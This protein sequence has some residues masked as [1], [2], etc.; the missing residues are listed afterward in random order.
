MRILARCYGES[1]ERISTIADVALDAMEHDAH[2]AVLDN[3]GR[4]SKGDVGAF[5]KALDDFGLMEL[6]ALAAQVARRLTFLDHLDE[7][8]ANPATLEKQIHVA[9]ESNLWVLGRNYDSM[10]SNKTLRAV[11]GEYCD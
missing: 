3:I 6:S 7:L 1:P 8:I 4:M 11:I 10:A 2:W 5:A 9:L